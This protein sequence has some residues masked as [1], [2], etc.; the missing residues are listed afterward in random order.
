M[1]TAAAQPLVGYPSELTKYAGTI[2][3][4]DAHEWVP[5]ELWVE[6]FG[7]ITRSFAELDFHNLKGMK[8]RYF[9]DV[10]SDLQNELNFRSAWYG[11][12][13]Y[14]F[15]AYD[16]DQRLQLMDF[17]GVDKQLIFPGNLAIN[18][19]FLYANADVPAFFPQITG[20]RRAFAV[21]MIHAQNEWVIRSQSY[22]DRL[23][24]VALLI[25]ETPDEILA[26]AKKLIKAG[27]R[28]VWFPS[29]MLP[30][31]KSPAHNDL[32][33][34]WALLADSDTVVTTHVGNEA[35]F[36]N[37]LEWR[38]AEAFKGFLVGEEINLDPWTMST[39]H[40]PSMNFL[41][42][43][44]TGG[45][46]KRHP[47]LRYAAVENGAHWLGPMSHSLK[48]WGWDAKGS[49]LWREK[50]P[51]LPSFY[52]QQNVRIAGLPWEP[53]D[54]YIRENGLEDCYCYASDFPH[55]EGGTDS[56]QF[57]TDNLADLGDGI[58]EKFFVK[59]AELI[60]P[61]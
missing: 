29:S 45:V 60:L 8:N 15:G 10:D 17:I 18:A 2:R 52:L 40:I 25:G 7:E 20:D 33:P 61:D 51:E 5:P 30:G 31:G 12:G 56:M 3:D 58:R 47:K 34:L 28:A 38:E 37:T 44:L 16:L 22:S 14:A 53:I 32:D 54:K 26:E 21:D 41:I 13:P 50:L 48:M 1:A 46:F 42:T 23:R 57:W 4:V 27:V 35:G 19:L 11:K 39:M 49:T 24:P 55:V 43:V 59:N 9:K 6:T 36:Y